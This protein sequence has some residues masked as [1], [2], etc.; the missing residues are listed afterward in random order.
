M[1]NTSLR[2]WTAQGGLRTRTAF[3]RSLDQPW[4]ARKSESF[5]NPFRAW[6]ADLLRALSWLVWGG[7][8][9]SLPA[10]EDAAGQ[11]RTEVARKGWLLYAAVSKAGDYDLFLA[12]PD[13]TEAR[14]LTRTPDFSEFGGRFSPDGKRMIY[15]RR[16]R[17]EPVNHD[18]WGAMGVPVIAQADGSNPKIM[19]QDG[20]W[21]WASWSP[22]GGQVAC[23]YKRLG[24]IRLLDLTTGQAVREL[25][26]QG[27]FQ[28]MFWSPDGRSLCG[29]ANLGGQ[30]WNIVSIDLTSGNST[31]LTRNLCCTPDWFQ[32]DSSRVIYSSRIPGLATDYGW[33][34]LMQ[35][36][37][38]GKERTLIYGER[39]RHIYYGC[40]SPDDQ[41][42]VFAAP[43]SDGGTDAT[44]AI[45]RMKD[46]PII[47][48]D[49]YKELKALYP[50]AGSG[51]V[52]RLPLAGFEPHWTYQDI[53]P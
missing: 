13:G 2:S 47:V 30:D 10:A 37:A 23:L 18:L 39:G 38:D 9:L 26:R 43:E 1:K 34:F 25:P 27:I 5:V 53:R 50:Q 32:R 7:L 31:L 6:V 24:K 41:Y 28:Q 44:L 42:I 8:A 46:T 35:A 3:A 33:T 12:R 40:A 14:N 4:R 45:V 51:P 19:G 29:T 11:L 16:P 21:P 15:R 48:P 22:D 49:D 52:L 36:T 17:G 20:D